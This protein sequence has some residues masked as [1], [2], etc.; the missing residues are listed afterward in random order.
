M[1]DERD[2]RGRGSMIMALALSACH[3]K[4]Q[5]GVALTYELAKLLQGGHQLRLEH[6]VAVIAGWESVR[7]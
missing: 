7:A 2:M 4:A 3:G 6:W 5:S 1:V